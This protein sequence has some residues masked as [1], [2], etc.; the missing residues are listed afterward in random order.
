MSK[1]L[2][3]SRY[4]SIPKRNFR[5]AIIKLCE[6]H[7]K[8][9]G[10]RKVLQLL[11]D[12]IVQLH[13]EFYPEAKNRGMGY[14]VWRTTAA[15]TKKPSYGQRAEDYQVKTVLLPLI[16]DED[17]E[18]RLV[19]KPAKADN[20]FIP[21]QERDIQVMARLIKSAYEQG[22]ILSGAELSVLLNRSLTAIGRYLKIYHQ[23]HPQEILP[24]KGNIL[25]QGS[26][27]T[28]KGVI[29]DLY[30]QGYPEIDIARLT[31]HNI[32]SVG[33]YI[34]TYRDVKLMLEKE[35][36]LMEMVRVTGKGRSTIIQYRK[37]V[38]LYHPNMK[39]LDNNEIENKEA[40]DK[41]KAP[42]AP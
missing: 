16:S 30:E 40:S 28:H 7:Y 34:K 9:L 17:I 24:T 29:I 5:N 26:S 25:D 20:Q 32:E 1:P 3:T 42:N 14:I 36:S 27:P 35:L 12:D 23:Q 38:Y 37:L 6:E 19:G 11:A 15:S 4:E 22:G 10:S 8:I 18:A 31:T 21:Q 33:R 13:Q 39:K 41:T 2:V